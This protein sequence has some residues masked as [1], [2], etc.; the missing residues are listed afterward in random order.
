MLRIGPSGMSEIFYEEG[1]KNTLDAP[2]WLATKNLNAF[3]YSFGRIFNLSH[4]TSKK[5][6]EEAEKNGIKI[7]VHAPYYINFANPDELTVEKNINYL[8]TSLSY[9]RDFKGIHCVF[10]PGSCMKMERGEAVNNVF[11]RLDLTL[12][13]VYTAGFSDLYIC[14]ETMGKIQQIG[15][16]DEII[17]FCK[18]DKCLIPTLDFGHINARTQGSIK[19]KDDY[20]FIFDKVINGLGEFKADNLHIHFAKIEYGLKGEIRHLNFDDELYGPNFEPLA[21]AITELNLHPTII[22]ESGGRMCEDAIQM[23]KIF[24]ALGGNKNANRWY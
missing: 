7:S 17:E 8:L 15:T 19:S 13:K 3:E 9:L 16:V 20:K 10:H 18:M 14:P 2:K 4:E 21:E 24:D 11:K 12:E 5:I 22:C 6:G 23:K 1:G